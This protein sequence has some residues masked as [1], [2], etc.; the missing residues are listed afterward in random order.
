MILS[1]KLSRPR[2][3]VWWPTLC[4]FAVFVGAVAI[5]WA[6][7]PTDVMDTTDWQVMIM[8][9]G[10]APA[11][12]GGLVWSFALSRREMKPHVTKLMADAF[13]RGSNMLCPGSA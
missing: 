13:L 4:G 1:S 2:W 5:G 10:G 3:R 8:L 12:V 7:S 9:C 11:A 6:M